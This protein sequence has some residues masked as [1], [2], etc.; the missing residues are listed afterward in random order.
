[1]V[2]LDIIEG[3]EKIAEIVNFFRDNVDALK[4]CK[5]RAQNL[6]DTARICES[7]VNAAKATYEDAKSRDKE[8]ETDSLKLAIE[9]LLRQMQR[10]KGIVEKALSMPTISWLTIGSQVRDEMSVVTEELRACS[11]QCHQAYQAW[12]FLLEK[13]D[14]QEKLEKLTQEVDDSDEVALLN[15]EF[16]DAGPLQTGI[17][18]VTDSKWLVFH[19]AKLISLSQELQLDTTLLDEL[20]EDSNK[21]EMRKDTYL[22]VL[23]KPLSAPKSPAHDR[24]KA[25][26]LRTSIESGE[27]KEAEAILTD[28]SSRKLSDADRLQDAISKIETIQAEIDEINRKMPEIEKEIVTVFHSGEKYV[29]DLESFVQDC[30]RDVSRRLASCEKWGFT[31]N[32]LELLIREAERAE[33]SLISQM[34]FMGTILSQSDS[35]GDTARRLLDLSNDLEGLRKLAAK[36]F[37]AVTHVP[38]RTGKR[39]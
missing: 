36:T 13:S 37:D 32:N 31:T 16:K 1:M 23:E 4:H 2:V 21:L 6:L 35:S 39:N 28:L 18:Q 38:S 30:M 29:A 12:G 20:R 10:A 3:A 5:K 27:K 9:Y 22:K 34:T 15:E 11:A 24:E 25:K 19:L 14:L 7:V 33:K 8:V 26:K 17:K